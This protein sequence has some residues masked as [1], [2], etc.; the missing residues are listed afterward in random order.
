MIRLTRLSHTEIAIN[1]DL[2]ESIEEV[3]DTTV[4]LISGEK[5]LV[6]E[7]VDQV[8]AK[9]VEYRRTVLAGM[10][11]VGSFAAGRRP[12]AAWFQPKPNDDDEEEP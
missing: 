10:G 12:S 11:S 2:I 5:L 6:L 4:R 1:C 8:I 7:S 3:P 9:V